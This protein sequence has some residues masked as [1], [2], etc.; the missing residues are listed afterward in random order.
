MVNVTDR[1]IYPS[2]FFIEY[3]FIER[4]FAR[5]ISRTN[6]QFMLQLT[7]IANFFFRTRRYFLG[8]NDSRIMILYR[9]INVCDNLLKDQITQ[10][11]FNLNTLIMSL[12]FFFFNILKISFILFS[13]TY[14]KRLN[15]TRV[16]ITALACGSFNM[17]FKNSDA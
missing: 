4:F 5:V 16:T 15:D 8:F 9:C 7:S 17:K 14:I 11:Y 6:E 1:L 2:N 10:Y 13:I 3:R 12:F